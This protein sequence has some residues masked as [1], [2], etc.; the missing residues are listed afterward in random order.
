MCKE[1]AGNIITFVYIHG[2]D[3]ETNASDSVRTIDAFF[4]CDVD[5]STIKARHKH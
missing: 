3:F 5:G 1:V 4:C 2:Y